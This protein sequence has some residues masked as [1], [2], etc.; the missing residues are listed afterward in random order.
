MTFHVRETVWNH[1]KSVSN[2]F[3]LRTNEA[4]STNGKTNGGRAM[5]ARVASIVGRS[6]KTM[7]T[8]PT[9]FS[10]IVKRKPVQWRLVHCKTRR[11]EG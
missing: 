11:P 10:A 5:M 8:D 7:V 9:D 2:T 3:R 1:G 4:V 6:K